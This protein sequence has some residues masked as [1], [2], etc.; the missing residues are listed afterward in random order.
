MNSGTNKIQWRA[1]LQLN[2]MRA[3][4][5]GLL[6]T[7]VALVTGSTSNESMGT[8]VAIPLVWA[9]L[10]L[11]VLLP[12]ALAAG[13]LGSMGV[14]FVGLFTIPALVFVVPGDPLVFLLHKIKPNLVPVQE[15]GF[16]NFSYV[17]NV[18]EP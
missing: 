17:I 5:G 14:P 15:I 4:L 6:V 7:I 13:Q 9:A 2:V 3:L 10:Y 11:V 16:L 12:I 8:I 1:T 18:Y